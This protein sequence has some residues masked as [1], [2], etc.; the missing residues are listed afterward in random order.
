MAEPST[1]LE[2]TQRQVI[3]LLLERIIMEDRKTQLEG[4]KMANERNLVTLPTEI[5]RL[6]ESTAAL[7]TELAELQPA[8]TT[9]LQEQ[10]LLTKRRDRLQD[11]LGS[12][13]AKFVLSKGELEKTQVRV[14]K[15]NST[16]AATREALASSQ[17]AS[18]ELTAEEEALNAAYGPLIL[19]LEAVRDGLEVTEKRVA[20]MRTRKGMLAA[21][22]DTA[23][24]TLSSTKADCEEVR[25]AL[26]ATRFRLQNVRVERKQCAADDAAARREIKEN[27]ELTASLL[28]ELEA[29][30]AEAPALAAQRTAATVE[31]EEALAAVERFESGRM[32][33]VLALDD[34]VEEPGNDGNDE[35]STGMMLDDRLVQTGL[36][37]D[38]TVQEADE[39]L[40][41]L[42]EFSETVRGV[43][44]TAAA[45]RDLAQRSLEL[46]SVEN[47]RVSEE[48]K[49]TLNM[50][51]EAMQK[52]Q[53]QWDRAVASNAAEL[54]ELKADALRVAD[55]QRSEVASIQLVQADLKAQASALEALASERRTLAEEEKA[56]QRRYV[57]L[58]EQRRRR[59]ENPTQNPT[60]RFPTKLPSMPIDLEEVAE[61]AGA[62]A[63]KATKTLL[64]FFG[65]EKPSQE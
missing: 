5:A 17:V 44:D 51:F 63:E 34:T 16:I 29:L 11:E 64:R 54:R 38:A 7:E 27:E 14:A 52:M 45:R 53:G 56:L 9:L 22:L 8:V 13:Q 35:Q 41:A 50:A 59:L 57:L 25:A 47:R 18:T 19:Q 65:Q 48:M 20:K 2:T 15:L 21:E 33:A 37:L 31:L 60:Q 58:R 49:L 30:K 36:R 4:T 39:R 6:R 24:G 28:Q 55:T 42:D 61:A 10:S 3:Q 32:A 12:A 46:L 62:N 40:M 26:K 1:E 23:S 43:M